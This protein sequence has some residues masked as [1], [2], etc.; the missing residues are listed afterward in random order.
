MRK[1]LG[2]YVTSDHHLDKL[3]ELCR[4]AERKDVETWVFLTHIGTRLT[5]DP[6]FTELARIAKVALCSE[7]FKDNNLQ[8]PVAGLDEKGFASQAWHAEMIHDCD[9][10]LTF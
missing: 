1:K 2:I 7:G 6:R 9:R 4:A 5:M 10:Y 8:K 3:I